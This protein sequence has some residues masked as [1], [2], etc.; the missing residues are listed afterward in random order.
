MLSLVQLENEV[1]ERMGDQKKQPHRGD[2]E[3]RPVANG[4]PMGAVCLFEYVGNWVI[5]IAQV[6]RC[7]SRMAGYHPHTTS[8]SGK[9]RL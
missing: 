4:E 5:P 9:V 1:R 3:K 8:R 6:R 2:P 7:L